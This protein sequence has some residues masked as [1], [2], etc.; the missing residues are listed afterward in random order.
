MVLGAVGVAQVLKGH[1][2]Q[3]AGLPAGGV[4]VVDRGDQTRERGVGGDGFGH[5]AA[6]H[7]G[8]IG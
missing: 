4:G 8:Q 5:G 1:L 2:E 3:V 7:G 6:E